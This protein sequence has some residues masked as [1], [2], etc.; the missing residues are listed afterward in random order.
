MCLCVVPFRGPLFVS[1]LPDTPFSTVDWMELSA[2]GRENKIEEW[3]MGQKEVRVV[4]GTAS[5]LVV[6]MEESSTRLLWGSLLEG[7]SWRAGGQGGGGR[8]QRALVR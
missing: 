7:C 3:V 8:V 4:P 5:L 6:G 1:H 2:D